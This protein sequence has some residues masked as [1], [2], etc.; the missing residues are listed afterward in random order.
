MTKREV[1]SLAFK[2]MGVYALVLCAA[3]ASSLIM[4]AGTIAEVAAHRPRHELNMADIIWPGL[5]VG[6]P[7]T[8]LLALGIVL[9][10]RSSRFSARMFPE[11]EK[12]VTVLASAQDIQAI[13][14]SVVGVLLLASA[15]PSIAQIAVNLH[16]RFNHPEMRPASIRG[17]WA[18][19]L[20]MC[21][22][23]IL[24]TGL[25]FGGRALS[26]FWF[27]LRTFRQ[28]PRT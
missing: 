18:S 8:L 3:H 10:M 21:A 5:F 26:N 1:G 24:G 14:F 4:W 11:P 17:T 22:K 6:L 23:V 2:L 9:I 27:K 15:L 16:H 25:F 7:C 19:F 12:S 28:P 13:A 20:T